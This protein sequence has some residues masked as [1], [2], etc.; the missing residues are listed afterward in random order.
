MVSGTFSTAIVDRIDCRGHQLTL[1][2]LSARLTRPEMPD[3][4]SDLCATASPA[5]VLPR[6]TALTRHNWSFN[7]HE[8]RSGIASFAVQATD[9]RSFIDPDDLASRCPTQSRTLGP[10]KS[11]S[12]PPPMSLINPSAT[13]GRQLWGSMGS[14]RG[15]RY[16]VAVCQVNL[17]YMAL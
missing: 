14:S 16:H 13:F 1:R 12:R 6:S 15:G 9:F 8:H 10:C 3:V 5:P 2:P 17:I 4:D 11:Q 7:R